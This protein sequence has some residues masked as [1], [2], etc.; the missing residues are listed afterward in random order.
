MKNNISE[1]E[2]AWSQS[3]NAQIA[4]AATKDRTE[5][6][7]EARPIIES[8]AKRRGIWDWILYLRGEKQNTPNTDL[9][10]ITLPQ[11]ICEMCK[12]NSLNLEIGRCRSCLFP[13]EYFPY[14]PNCDAFP[15]RVL[16][17]TC[18]KCGA[19]LVSQK[20]VTRSLRLAND[21]LDGIFFIVL[22]SIIMFLLKLPPILGVFLLFIYYFVF[23]SLWQRTPAKFITGTKV[24]NADGSK[25]S[26]AKIAK[27]T[28]IRFI[29]FE[30]L[31]Y[32]GDKA[33]GWHDR[34]SQTFVIRAKRFPTK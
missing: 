14:C 24:V 11:Y 31:S 22:L 2:Q 32:L 8:E 30:G 17:E 3:S 9:N 25:P 33:C 12:E 13:P 1:M 29:P 15:P 4:K 20:A 6:S 23:E 27:R 18:S 5:Y 28:A 26:I 21:I 19:K 16:N 34:W 10:Q 7:P